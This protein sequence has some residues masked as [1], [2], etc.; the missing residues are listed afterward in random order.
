MASQPLPPPPEPGF[1]REIP[2][3]VAAK[4][5]QRASGPLEPNAALLKVARSGDDP[6]K[7]RE[8]L[9]SGADV[10]CK[11]SE[12]GETPLAK[13]CHHGHMNDVKILLETS[14]IE[15]KSNTGKTPLAEA[16]QYGHLEIVKYLHQEGAR[17]EVAD[18]G[19]ITPLMAASNNGHVKIVKYL[20]QVGAQIEVKDNNGWTPL[21]SVSVNGNLEIVKYLLK[22]ADNF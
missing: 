17:I 4:K 11:D 8:L 2:L 3:A 13:S 10:H 18:N 21:L 19:G 14:H 9:N 7:I 15:S 12:T 22:N 16:A 1:L 6:E 5:K 20:H